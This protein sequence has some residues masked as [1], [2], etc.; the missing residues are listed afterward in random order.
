MHPILIDFGVVDLPLLGPT[1]LFLP[2]YGVLFA[3][4]VVL[5]WAWFLRRA[6]RLDLPEER[7]F[8]LTF[9]SLLAGILGAKVLLV[10]IDW[11]VYWARPAEILGT[12]RSAGVLLGGIAAGSATFALYA[13]RHALPLWSLADAIAAPLALA[14]AFGR[15]GCFAGGCCWGIPVDAGQ[16]LAVVFRDE[17]AH[18]LTGVPLGEPLLAIQLLEAG[19]DLAL[20][21]M[22]TVLWHRR[23]QPAGSVF[24]I[25][26]L[27]YAIGRAL[28]EEGRGD[29]HRGLF[30]GGALSTSQILSLA[31]AVLAIAM[32]VRGLRS[33]RLARLSSA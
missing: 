10:L 28:L 30:F 20:V 8:N 6:R 27:V 13:W 17:Q 22:L 26:A 16:P 12:I 24:W 7:L 25:Y 3:G 31:V 21:G 23:V 5:A 4:A 11:D 15:L 18:A 29:A 33:R 9:F 14:Q 32:L 19:F 1:R 2:T